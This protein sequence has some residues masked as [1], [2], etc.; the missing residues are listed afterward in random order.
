MS[1]KIYRI[2]CSFLLLQL[3]FIGFISA[4]SEV[5]VPRKSLRAER[6][7]F[8]EAFQ[9]LIDG[10]A[11]ARRGKGAI[12]KALGFYLKVYAYNKDCPE[13]NYKI[14]LCY[15]RS[16][17]KAK[18]LEFLK[19]AYLKD[20]FVSKDV[21]YLL[22]RA[23]QLNLD[24]DKAV[25]EYN[26]FLNALKNRQK[27]KLSDM[28]NKNIEECKAGKELVSKPKRTAIKNLG[29]SIN[30]A[31]DDY[32]ALLLKGDSAMFLTSRRPTYKRKRPDRVNYMFDENIYFA[33]SR[34]G[35]WDKA[36]YLEDVGF[37]SKR[38]DAM[39]WV[40]DDGKT[41]YLYDGYH[42]NG[43]IMVSTMKKDGSWKHPKRIK[44]K[45]N[46]N[47]TETSMSITQDGNIIYFVSND[48][49][50]SLG[51]KDIYVSNRKQNGKW[52]RPQNVGATIN[53]PYDEESVYVKPDGKVMFFSSK[54]HNSM[55]GYDIF[56]SEKDAGGNWGKPE[57]IGYPVNTPDDELFYRPSN[58]EKIAYY[59]AKRPDTRGGYDIY[60]VIYLGSEKKML[61]SSEEQ[62]CAYF[63]KPITEIFNR[64]SEEAK[65]DSAV[66][67]KGFIT[68]I[69]HGKPV[70]A[71]LDLIDID[72][73][74][75]VATTVSDTT[76]AYRIYLPALKKYGVE[77]NA[78][79]YMFFLD[80]LTL[81]Q[82]IENNEVIK[83]FALTKIE[84]GAKIVL[85]NIYFETGKAIL[86]AKSN[87]ELDKLVTFLQENADIKVEISGHTDNVGTLVANTKLSENRAKAVVTYLIKHGIPQ[88]QMVY[89]GY[90]FTQPIAPNTTK[91]GKQLNRRVEF[92]ILS[93][94]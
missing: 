18:A 22:G 12:P 29:D 47:A 24:F 10:D 21:L 31:Y 6:Q 94:E 37:N 85:N 42:K 55:G 35:K 93:K 77:I 71:K 57:N 20:P 17:T 59:S 92:K 68:E 28:V 25:E 7:G 86:T 53:T 49:R 8:G 63:D 33:R 1:R 89:K 87:T 67:M 76:G 39:V 81:P 41:R 9:N 62:L 64:V 73:S 66:Y 16:D 82:K 60:K 90:A 50:E 84:V 56:R 91:A 72:K 46:T 83:N 3:F 14:A 5:K 36:E 88:E 75:V 54:G 40:S 32:N 43:D 34:A 78:K 26:S 11:W 70:V 74:Q 19:A 23:Y 65:I 48:T 2:I 52:G 69:K 79:N 15:F 4:Q 38:N 44:G 58:N 61:L 45:L 80:I 27:K 30:S 13:L 51:G